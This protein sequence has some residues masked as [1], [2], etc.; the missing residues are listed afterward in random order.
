MF[1]DLRKVLGFLFHDILSS[2]IASSFQ[3]FTLTAFHLQ[4][5]CVHHMIIAHKMQHG[6]GNKERKLTTFRMPVFQSLRLYSVLIQDDIA[7]Q[8]FSCVRI[9]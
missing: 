9:K 6:M 2:E 5:L 4:T 7:K 3:D 1:F 8:E